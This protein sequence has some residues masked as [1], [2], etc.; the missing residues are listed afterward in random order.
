[1]HECAS[2]SW[3]GYEHAKSPKPVLQT[4]LRSQ[5]VADGGGEP[6][7]EKRRK[8]KRRNADGVAR[9]VSTTRVADKPAGKV[10][11]KPYWGKPAVRFDEGTE[12]KAVMGN[13]EPTA[14]TE[15]ERVGNPPPKTART[16]VLLYSGRAARAPNGELR[17]ALARFVRT[18]R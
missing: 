4:V 2:R 12:G 14:H 7:A 8:T 13:W 6:E 15:R 9:R 5:P 11:G 3:Q 18:A 10:V 17:F 1:M 16:K